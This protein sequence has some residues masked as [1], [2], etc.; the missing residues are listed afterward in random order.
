[1][2]ANKRMVQ[3]LFKGDLQKKSI[4]STILLSFFKGF[5]QD[6]ALKK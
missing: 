6:W 2:V 3:K 1:M 5:S 4:M